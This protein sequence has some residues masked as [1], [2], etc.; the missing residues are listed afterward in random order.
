MRVFITGGGGFIG[1]NLTLALEKL[2]HEIKNFDISEPT[3]AQHAQYW[4]KGDIMDADLISHSLKGFSP[5][6][7]IHLAARTECDENTTVEKGYLV[8]TVGT[9]NVLEAIKSCNTVKRVI[10]TSTQY[11]C[12]PSRQPENDD[13]YF[14]HTVYGHSK[15][16]TEK[17]TKAAQL[18]CTWTLIRPVNIWGAYH[19]RYGK[20]FWRIAAAGLYVHPD[21]E[22]P[23]RTY[24]YVGNVIW[25]ILGIFEAPAERVNKEIFYVGDQPIK[26]DRWSVGFFKAFRGKEP[27]RIPLPVMKGLG[28][29]GDLISTVIR[30]PFFI[31]SSRLQ[32]MTQ[33][34]ISPVDK[35][36]ALLGEAPYTL[37][38]GIE[39]V[40]SWYNANNKK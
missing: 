39:E 5:D 9:A 34:Y 28:I 35:T 26:I 4:E 3:L 16:E 27:L 12:G 11:V 21:V 22:A 33:D 6:W 8:N 1:T 32:S 7:V 14:P 37:E 31:T 15:V 24:G 23:T 30:K 2:G 40:V 17:L 19:A 13:D 36:T 38:A 10:I 20:E 18:P 25:Q 29:I